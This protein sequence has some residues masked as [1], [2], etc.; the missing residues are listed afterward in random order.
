M[1]LEQLAAKIEGLEGPDA[2]KLAE[3]R[4]AS[5]ALVGAVQDMLSTSDALLRRFPLDRV[6]RVLELVGQDPRISTRARAA[7]EEIKP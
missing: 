2:L 6:G 7:M 1:T 3:L 4:E 5:L